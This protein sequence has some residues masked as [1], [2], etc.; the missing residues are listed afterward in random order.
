VKPQGRCSASEGSPD[1]NA[2]KTELKS[3]NGVNHWLW[4]AIDANGDVLDILV[5]RRRN[6]KAAKRFF[7]KLVA[8]YGEPSVEFTELWSPT[9]S[10]ATSSQS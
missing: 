7:N 5:Q 6:T 4:R 1:Q 9:S 8:R 3:L 10:A 2:I